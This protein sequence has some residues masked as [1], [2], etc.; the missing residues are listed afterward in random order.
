MPS[1]HRTLT[2]G[3]LGQ[4]EQPADDP[5]AAGTLRTAEEVG[6]LVA[7]RGGVL[8]TGGLGGVMQAA[9]KGAKA[10]GGTTIGFL[11]SMDRS[12]ANPYVDIVFPT[13]LGRARNL[14]TARGCDALVMIGGGCGTLNELTVAYADG[15]P[16]VVLR[17]SGGWSDRIAP[18]LYDGR[19][20]DE[21]RTVEI[22]FGDT[23]AAVVD[24]AFA[25]A[26]AGGQPGQHI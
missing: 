15:R 16:V 9:S 25:A 26:E 12:T 18:V 7:R 3:I 8:V 5:V 13:G 20:L 19:Y 14:L 24:L 21:R 23:P 6:L 4:N 22:L 2:I 10:G 11:P 17:G 1:A